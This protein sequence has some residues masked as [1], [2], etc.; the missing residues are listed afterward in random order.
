MCI[1][2]LTRGG[3]GKY[4]FFQGRA[5]INNKY[6]YLPPS[7]FLFYCTTKLLFGAWVLNTTEYLGDRAWL[8]QSSNSSFNEPFWKT[9]YCPWYKIP[10]TMRGLCGCFIWKL[11]SIADLATKWDQNQEFLMLR[12][13]VMRVKPPKFVISYVTCHYDMS[14][15]PK[16]RKILNISKSTQ[17]HLF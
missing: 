13:Q 7:Q 14:L 1:S 16:S 15:W 17:F 11:A 4:V 3:W 8:L 9:A 5:F 6:I 2:D 12:C 10:E